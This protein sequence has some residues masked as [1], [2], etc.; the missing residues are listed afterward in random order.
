MVKFMNARGAFD[1]Q[2]YTGTLY[3]VTVSLFLVYRFLCTQKRSVAPHTPKVLLLG[4][5]GSGKTVQ[6]AKLAERYGL[7][8]GESTHTCITHE[9]A[10]LHAKSGELSYYAL[11]VHVQCMCTCT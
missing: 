3:T 8:N 1:T 5:S 2:L 10:R 9:S 7:I 11:H 4:P 6:A